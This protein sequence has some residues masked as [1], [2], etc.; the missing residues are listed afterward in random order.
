MTI[1]QIGALTQLTMK[2]GAETKKRTA[3]EVIGDDTHVSEAVGTLVLLHLPRKH[4]RRVDQ[5][6]IL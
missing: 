5:G 2:Y 4:S 1:F 6:D 3:Q